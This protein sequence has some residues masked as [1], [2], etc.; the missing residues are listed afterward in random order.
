M[1]EDDA[2]KKKAMEVAEAVV[3]LAWPTQGYNLFI[4]YLHVHVLAVY[5]LLIDVPGL[6]KSRVRPIFHVMA[7]L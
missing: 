2:A 1:A 5:V 7:F 4:P 6:L 3:V